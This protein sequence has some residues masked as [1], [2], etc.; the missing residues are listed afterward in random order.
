MSRTV[1]RPG[2]SGRQTADLLSPHQLIQLIAQATRRAVREPN[3]KLGYKY[4]RFVC[5]ATTVN[6]KAG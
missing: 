1:D 2:L 5:C 4:I 3:L 6:L